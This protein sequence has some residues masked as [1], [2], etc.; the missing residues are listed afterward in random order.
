MQNTTLATQ[1]TTPATQ[2]AAP[3]TQNATP[4]TQ[5]ARP[6][7]SDTAPATHTQKMNATPARAAVVERGGGMVWYNMVER[8]LVCG[9]A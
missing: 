2:N 7:T 5:N 1:N 4:T 6:A 9:R 3:A 8:G